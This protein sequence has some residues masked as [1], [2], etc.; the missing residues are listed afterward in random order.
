MVS[1]HPHTLTLACPLS[2]SSSSSRFLRCSVNSAPKRRRSSFITASW[3]ELAGV[4]LFSAI[5]FTAVKAIANSPLGESLQRKMEE[6]KTFAVENSSTFKALAGK[7]RKESFWYGEDR[8]RWLGPISYEYPSYLTGELPGDYGFDI[9]GLGQD[10]VA[11]QK[12]F[13]FE[14]LHARWAMLASVGALI[15]E[16]LDLLG[17]FH[18]VEPVWWRVGYSKLKGD[19]LDYLGIQGLHFAGSQGVVVIAICQALLMVGPEYAR[20]CGIEALE[21]LGIYLPGDI[22]YPGGALFDPL[23]LSNDPEAFE[24]LKVKE[25]KNGRLAMVAWLGFYVQAALTGKGPVQNLI[26]HISDPFHNNLLGSLN[27]IKVVM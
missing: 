25:I 9:A 21:P 19:T 10:P 14:I 7:A 17:A 16:I 6:R 11:L 24:E 23:N 2:V 13:N 8:P 12:Y 1:L 4:L 22:N 27:F 5:P 15:P 3:Q 18:F 26:D 20:Y